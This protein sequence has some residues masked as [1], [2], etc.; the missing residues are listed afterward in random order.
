MDVSFPYPLGPCWHKALYQSIPRSH[1]FNNACMLWRE[2]RAAGSVQCFLSGGGK[3]AGKTWHA[4]VQWTYLWSYSV[5]L[6]FHCPSLILLLS[7]PIFL[8]ICFAAVVLFPFLCIYHISASVIS[9]L[10]FKPQRA[11]MPL[12]VVVL[13]TLYMWYNGVVFHHAD[14]RSIPGL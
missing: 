12:A 10:F 4:D 6:L 11:S 14:I 13:H 9:Y 5:G 1:L 7:F 2:G 8:H 3:P